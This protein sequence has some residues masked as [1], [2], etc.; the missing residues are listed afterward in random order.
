MRPLDE[1]QIIQKALEDAVVDKGPSVGI[2]KATAL[3]NAKRAAQL[4]KLAKRQ[5]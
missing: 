2:P 1:K 3:A 4:L 5:K